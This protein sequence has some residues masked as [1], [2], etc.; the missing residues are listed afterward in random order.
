[1]DFSNHRHVVVQC[2]HMKRP[3]V[4]SYLKSK[5]RKSL[6]FGPA[7][8]YREHVIQVVFFCFDIEPIDSLI[9]HYRSSAIAV[10]PCRDR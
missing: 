8:C 3:V 9:V 10:F 2:V 1:M 7:N 4:Q 6:F 5:Q